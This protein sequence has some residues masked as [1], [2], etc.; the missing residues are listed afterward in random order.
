MTQLTYY[1]VWPVDEVHA[2]RA[3]PGLYELRWGFTLSDVHKATMRA[4]YTA[5]SQAADYSDRVSA[6]W[7]AVVEYLY[8][9]VEEPSADDLMIAGRKAVDDAVHGYWRTHGV[10]KRNPSA[11]QE[12]RV[13]F[14]RFW[15][16]FSRPASF[17]SGLVDK[18]ALI[19]IWPHIRPV[20]QEALL[21]LAVH[22]SYQNAAD[23]MG[24]KYSAFVSR[25]AKG[26]HEFLRL[27]HEGECPSKPWGTDRRVEG[28]GVRSVTTK[29]RRRRQ[30]RG[31]G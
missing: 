8:T 19:A 23:A 27:W 31:S 26:R 21:A 16:T 15:W 22:D 6:A 11:G 18:M 20:N 4:V 30:E 13:N 14:Q 29:L 25:V 2:D 17:E 1:P 10:D 12:N 3:S 28:G 24:L 9:A 7:F 5:F